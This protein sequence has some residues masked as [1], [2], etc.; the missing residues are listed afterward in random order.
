MLCQAFKRIVKLLSEKADVD[1]TILNPPEFYGKPMKH[2]E[3]Q[4][5]EIGQEHLEDVHVTHNNKKTQATSASQADKSVKE[6]TQQQQADSINE[7]MTAYYH[8]TPGP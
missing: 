8:E 4:E 3:F 2:K 5:E 7:G 1:F 6:P